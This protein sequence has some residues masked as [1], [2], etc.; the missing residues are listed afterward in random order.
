MLL[1]YLCYVLCFTPSQRDPVRTPPDYTVST[2]IITFN[3]TTMYPKY[4]L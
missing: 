4:I 3:T 2:I 1:L